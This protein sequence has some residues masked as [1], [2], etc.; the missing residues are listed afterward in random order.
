MKYNQSLFSKTIDRTKFAKRNRQILYIKINNEIITIYN[1]VSKKTYEDIPVLGL[2]T[3]NEDLCIG[4]GKE[5]R[6]TS[7]INSVAKIVPVFNDPEWFINNEMQAD[8]LLR[9]FIQEVYI[10]WT[11]LL[12]GIIIHPTSTFSLKNKAV[13]TDK[14]HQI[15]E[16]RGASRSLIHYGTDLKPNDLESIKFQRYY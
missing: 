10:R 9:L 15:C 11:L 6:F 1:S 14:L 4:F 3:D 5:A 7:Q 2:R 16:Q 8:F 12:P 13:V